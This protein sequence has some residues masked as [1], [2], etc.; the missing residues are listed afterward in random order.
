MKNQ[1][2]YLLLSLFAVISFVNTAFILNDSK[3]LTLNLPIQSLEAPPQYE[4]QKL[5][6][7]EKIM[8]NKIFRKIKKDG[9][10]FI[11]LDKLAKKSKLFSIITCLTGLFTLIFI[12]IYPIVALLMLTLILI[13]ALITASKANH[14]Y[15]N[16]LSTTTQK[17]M[18]KRSEKVGCFGFLIVLACFIGALF[19]SLY[20]YF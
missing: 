5:P 6:F 16:L 13:F 2:R 4:V 17:R 9:E 10:K 3:D 14:V 1:K 12:W 11:N 18:V 8:M 20:G 19:L 7:F 15:D